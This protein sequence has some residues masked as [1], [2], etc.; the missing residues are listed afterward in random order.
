MVVE[1]HDI[2]QA[3]LVPDER[4]I[5][6]VEAIPMDMEDD[7]YVRR[8]ENRRRLRKQVMLIWA[9]LILLVI[10]IALAI[11]VIVG[12]RRGTAIATEIK[13]AAT[14]SLPLKSAFTTR[15]SCR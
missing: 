6:T 7:N 14:D 8:E 2:V 13:E 4:P 10:V 5:E 3:T 11:V 15:P 12:D 1:A 9:P